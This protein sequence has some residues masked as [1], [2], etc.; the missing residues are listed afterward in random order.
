M[1]LTGAG[2]TKNFGGYLSS[3]MWTQIFN[4]PSVQAH[5]NLRTLLLNDL[6]FE[7][8]YSVVMED[9]EHEQFSDEEQ[10]ALMTAI[11]NA[12]R[13]LD[14]QISR[15]NQESVGYFPQRNLAKLVHHLSTYSGSERALWFT[16]NQDIFM[17]RHFHWRATGAPAFQADFYGSRS[18]QLTPAPIR[19]PSP[20][21]SQEMLNQQLDGSVTMHAGPSYIKLHGS[22]CWQSWTDR[23]GMVLGMNKET[24]IEDE[25]LLQC[26]FDLLKSVIQDGGRKLL[27]IGYGFRDIHVN[28]MLLDGVMSHGLELFV[29][30]P[31]PPDRFKKAFW[32]ALEPLSKGAPKRMWRGLRGYFPYNLHQVFHG[33]SGADTVAWREIK[34]SFR[35]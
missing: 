23:P 35:R 12:Y 26:Y 15:Y 5:D 14:Q 29:I 25:P 13:N 1:V 34:E 24:V 18:M 31:A 16:L 32:E 9:E 19:L 8:V 27:I 3:E 17:E 22:Y 6:N 4:H 28:K 10:D 7:N 30:H 20:E 2:F 11:E 33:N 21:T